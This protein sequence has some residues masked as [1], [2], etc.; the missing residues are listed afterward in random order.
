[1]EFPHVSQL[2]E[3][4]C[5]PLRGEVG[6]FGEPVEFDR[7]Y[8]SAKVGSL[9]KAS[10]VLMLPVMLLVLSVWKM[11]GRQMA[12]HVRDTREAAARGERDVTARSSEPLPCPTMMA[13]IS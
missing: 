8:V 2:T 3:R 5:Q 1:M 6:R 11:C 9:E 13:M 10:R 4:L 12:F 7:A